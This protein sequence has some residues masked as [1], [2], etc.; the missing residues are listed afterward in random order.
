MLNNKKVTIVLSF[1]IAICMWTYVVGETNPTVTK[2]FKDIPIKI[3]NEKILEEHGLA[4]SEIEYETVSVTLKGTRN[5][6]NKIMDTDISAFVDLEE[7]AKG[8]N[9][10][11]VHIQCPS[12]MEFENSSIQKVKVK[13]ENLKTKEVDVTVKYEGTGNMD[14]KP[15][16]LSVAPEKVTVRGAESLVD[17]VVSAGG[18]IDA[19]VV[20]EKAAMFNIVIKPLDKEGD[21]VAHVSVSQTMVTVE[22]QLTETKTVPIKAIID[23]DN[24][25]GMGRTYEMPENVVITGSSTALENIEYVECEPIDISNITESCRLPLKF[26]LPEGISISEKS[27]DSYVLNVYVENT[28]EKI[29]E[30]DSGDIRI[31]GLAENLDAAIADTRIKV[32]VSGKESD[33]V[34]FDAGNI[35]LSVNL[36][37]IAEGRHKVNIIAG[38]DG[39]YRTVKVEPKTITVI[40]SQEDSD[41]N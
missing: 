20:R 39:A 13:V 36:E 38:V 22:A 11:R 25:A 3:K 18:I 35:S 28:D 16:T 27:A 9:L 29:F 30:Y 32:T 21:E 14:I 8:E 31:N 37:D 23:N 12:Y 2:T 15:I 24:G 33:L 40:I 10:L 26:I 34:S 5:R 4:I 7:A 19:G 17:S 6:M 1:V 41:N